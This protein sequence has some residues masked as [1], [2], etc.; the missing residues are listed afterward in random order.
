MSDVDGLQHTMVFDTTADGGVRP[1]P[2]TL[3]LDALLDAI[4][5]DP[6]LDKDDRRCELVERLQRAYGLVASA[7]ALAEL[8][9]ICDP[10]KK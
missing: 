7:D 1:E 2:E 4:G 5:Q 6:A 3:G 9:Q 10:L 8:D